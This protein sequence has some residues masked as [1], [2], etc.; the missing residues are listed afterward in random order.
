VRIKNAR[1]GGTRILGVPAVADRV[2]QTVVAMELERKVEPV[3]HPGS[4]GYRPGR[5]ALDAVAAS[6][7][8]A[9]RRFAA[10][11]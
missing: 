9:A 10:G 4:Y 1:G 7:A 5:S 2:A 8:D 6:A 3:F 11:P